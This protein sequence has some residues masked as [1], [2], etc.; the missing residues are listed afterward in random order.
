MNLVGGDGSVSR[1]CV[2]LWGFH[3]LRLGKFLT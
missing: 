3:A 1:T 2:R